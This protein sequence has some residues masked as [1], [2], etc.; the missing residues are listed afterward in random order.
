MAKTTKMAARPKPSK[1]EVER[2]FS[3]VRQ[4][5]TAARETADP[6]TEELL[7]RREAEVREAVR[8]SRWKAWYRESQA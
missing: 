2:E 1:A 6:K 3:G 7:R 8:G 4:E 5:V